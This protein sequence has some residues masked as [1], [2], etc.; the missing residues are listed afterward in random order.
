MVLIKLVFGRKFKVQVFY[1]I[2]ISE[3]LQINFW[4]QIQYL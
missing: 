1:F 4:L 3:E 2:I